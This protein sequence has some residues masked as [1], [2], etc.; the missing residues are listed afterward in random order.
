MIELMLP[1]FFFWFIIVTNIASNRFG[2]QTF[3]DLDAE[4]QLQKINADPKRFK[5]GSVLIVIEQ[6]SLVCLALTLFAAFNSYSI[7]LAAVW[8]VSRTIEGL[9]QIYYKKSYWGLLGIA[10]KYSKTSGSEKMALKDS[11]LSILRTKNTV[12]TFAQVLFSVGTVAYSVLFATSTTGVPDIIGWLG[13]VAGSIYGLGSAIKLVKSNVKV[14]WSIGG[15]LILFFEAVLGGWLL[16]SP[17][18]G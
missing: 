5:T 9:I 15:L 16:F 8:T 11:A 3:S 1:G 4:A 10:E 2:Y 7:V 14:V 12:F 6:V 18:I 13:I 17:L